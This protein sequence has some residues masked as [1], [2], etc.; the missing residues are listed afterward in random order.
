MRVLSD[1]NAD[2]LR[3]RIRSGAIHIAQADAG[4]GCTRDQY[5]R[6]GGV[7]FCSP[8]GAQVQKNASTSRA[9]SRQTSPVS[10][11]LEST[12]RQDR[13]RAVGFYRR[14]VDQK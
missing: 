7:D 14:D 8:R 9:G 2:W 13:R 10:G 11:P 3:E 5:R 6:A 12:S 1:A 4:A